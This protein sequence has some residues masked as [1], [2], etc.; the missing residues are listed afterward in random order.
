MIALSWLLLG[1]GPFLFYLNKQLDLQTLFKKWFNRIEVEQGWSGQRR[2]V[3]GYSVAGASAIIAVMGAIVVRRL[4]RQAGNLRWAFVF[5]GC[6]LVGFLFQ[7][8]PL[9]SVSGILVFWFFRSFGPAM[10]F[11][12]LI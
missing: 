8:L 9:G 1:M 5:L 3:V 2:I 10:E 4:P 7:Y 6:L 11:G 12:S